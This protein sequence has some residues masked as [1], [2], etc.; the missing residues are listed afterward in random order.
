M[1]IS[2]AA[3]HQQGLGSIRHCRCL[4]LFF[5]AGLKRL[6]CTKLCIWRFSAGQGFS[7]CGSRW[8]VGNGEQFPGRRATTGAPKALHCVAAG[9]L[10]SSNNVTSSTSF[11]TVHLLPKGFSLEHRGAKLAFFPGRHL[12]SLRPWGHGRIFDGS[13]PGVTEIEHVL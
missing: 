12:T 11:N 7:T 8:G 3:C 2:Q 9:A 6:G 10:K 13:R 1:Q 4:M 5:F